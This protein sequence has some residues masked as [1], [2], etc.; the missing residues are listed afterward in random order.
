VRAA[1]NG[2]DVGSFDHLGLAA[3]DRS[4]GGVVFHAVVD[5]FLDG[6]TTRTTPD[7]TKDAIGNSAYPIYKLKSDYSQVLDASNNPI[8]LDYYRTYPSSDPAYPTAQS[9]Y[10]FAFN[11]GRN[12]PG[13]MTVA[14]DQGIYLQGDYNTFVKKPAAIMADTI[15]A[16]SVNCVSPGTTPDPLAMP[17]AEI[18]CL[19]PDDTI[20]SSP[21]TGNPISSSLG[22][23]YGAE[24]T[25]INAAFLSFTIRSWGN[26]GS[27]R[28]YS[29]GNYYSGGLN[30]YMRLFEDWSGK[31]L[32]YNG[33]LVSLGTPLEFNGGF[34]PGGNSWSYFNVPNRNFSYDADF[35][36]FPQLPPMTPSVIYLQQ[37]V[38]KKLGS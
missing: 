6:S 28:G 11:G 29:Y 26:L 38:F 15:T 7:P 4:E 21:W 35:N 9:Y 34:Q 32:N 16:L 27:G 2:T 13:A 33:S 14:S 8:I 37:Q 36:S 10:A 3:A 30:N 20:G 23:M 12:L 1:A 18:N 24:T 22:V 19:I 17:T 31:N 5:D 25:S